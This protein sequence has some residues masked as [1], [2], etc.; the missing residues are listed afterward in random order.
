LLPEISVPPVLSLTWRL[1][2]EIAAVERHV[3]VDLAGIREHAILP[4]RHGHVALERRVE[5][6]ITLI[7][8]GQMD[9][10]AEGLAA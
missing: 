6:A 1:P 4:T 9:E 2:R 8:R 3:S 10:D 5:Q 7:T